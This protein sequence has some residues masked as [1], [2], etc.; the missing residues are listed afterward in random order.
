MIGVR[1]LHVSV[2]HRSTPVLRDVGFQLSPGNHLAVMG[3]NGSGKSMLL[4]AIAGLVPCRTDRL[5][6]PAP[7]GVVFQD[8][9]VGWTSASV[10]DEIRFALSCRGAA[11]GSVGPAVDGALEAFG[12]EHLRHTGPEK[13]SGGEQQRLQLAAVMATAPRTL[14]LD[15]PTAHLDPTGVASLERALRS[16]APPPEIVIRATHDPEVALGA[17]RLVVLVDGRVVA[18]DAPS[19]V[20]RR[21]D[22][23]T[24]GI[25]LPEPLLVAGA[26]EEA[27]IALDPRPLIWSELERAWP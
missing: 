26:L 27:G 15:E 7:I 20:F 13:L 23:G 17:D 16:L 14:L 3:A 19:D 21:P 12:L 10:E 25:E 6:L 11:D 9:A 1:G 22:A 2:S 4:A 18:D 8:P 5:D 24:L